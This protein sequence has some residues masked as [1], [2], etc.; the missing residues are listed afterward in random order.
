M[1]LTNVTVTVYDIFGRTLGN[2]VLSQ[3]K[4]DL[5]KY[6]SGIYYL[7]LLSANKKEVFRLMKQ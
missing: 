2:Q 1:N 4:I 3:N 6:G 7:E 5:T